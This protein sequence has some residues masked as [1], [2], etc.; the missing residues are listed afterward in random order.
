M[1]ILDTATQAGCIA[2]DG[3]CDLTICPHASVDCRYRRI[4]DAA[5]R[6]A[7]PREP[8]AETLEQLREVHFMRHIYHGYNDEVRRRERERM[9]R[10]DEGDVL[11]VYCAHPLWQALWGE[12]IK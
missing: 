6:T 9:R 4:V 11:A 1:S 2:Q 5:L 7:Y 8:S 3:T 12:D 10:L